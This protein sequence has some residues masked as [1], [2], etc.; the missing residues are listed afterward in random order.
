M[1]TRAGTELAAVAQASVKAHEERLFGCLTEGERKE[2]QRIL[3]KFRQEAV[4]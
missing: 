4:V 2:L 1:P 3:R